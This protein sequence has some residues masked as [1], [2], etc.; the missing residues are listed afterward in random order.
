LWRVDRKKKLEGK[1]GGAHCL[2]GRKK[3]NSREADKGLATV[4]AGGSRRRGGAR[5]NVKSFGKKGINK[6]ETAEIT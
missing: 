4:N 5:L 2:K 1:R 6:N 3:V